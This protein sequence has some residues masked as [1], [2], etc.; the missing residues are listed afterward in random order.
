MA[1]CPEEEQEPGIFICKEKETKEKAN[2]R[3]KI[4]N[5]EEENKEENCPRN[6]KAKK[7]E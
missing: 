6:I 7:K 1:E 5:K 4:R 3:R 2:N